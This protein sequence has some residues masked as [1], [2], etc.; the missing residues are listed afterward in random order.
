MQPMMMPPRI[1]VAGVVDAVDVATF[2]RSIAMS[3]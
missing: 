2:P 3:R 1:T